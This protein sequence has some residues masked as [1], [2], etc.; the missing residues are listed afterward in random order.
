MS[1]YASRRRTWCL[2]G[3]LIAAT[4]LGAIAAGCRPG[5][6]AGGPVSLAPPTRQ[7]LFRVGVCDAED[8]FQSGKTAA[9]AAADQLG[10][11]PVK[12]VIVS[13]C[14]EDKDR[15]A[16]VLDGVHA[17]FPKAVVCGGATYG[18]FAQ[19]GVAGGESVAVLAIAGNDIDVAAACRP[20]MGAAGLTLTE[21][22]DL[23]ESNLRAA[24]AALAKQL[25]TSPT[26][27]LAI[28]IADAHSPKNGALV[29]GIRGVLGKG[30]PITGGSVNKN[31]GQTFVYW[32]GQMLQDAAVAL[33][34]SGD[35][36]IAMAGRQAKENDKV[37]STAEAAGAEALAALA[38]QNCRPA[39][40]IAFD[41]AGRKGRLTNV[42]DELAA[43]QRALGTELPLFG[44][45]NAGEIG[46]ADLAD[47][48]PGVHSSG[49]G[50]HVMLTVV[51]W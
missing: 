13:E 31:A 44:T 25:P 50:W 27:R 8:P 15:K 42:A 23:L 12:A 4:L 41:C 24:G 46:P 2:T 34:L 22:K 5:T 9:R 3:G 43:M 35:F 14:Y 38:R 28:I 33:M 1:P 48:E 51:G 18:S 11:A 29:E 47:T 21:H 32:R 17:V 37:I 19:S 40:A 45:Y 49:V 16:K 26:N 36:R 20:K 30:F 10:A 39:A 7:I 6:R